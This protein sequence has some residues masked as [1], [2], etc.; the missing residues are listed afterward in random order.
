MSEAYTFNSGTGSVT[1]TTPANCLWSASSNVGWLEITSEDGGPGDGSVDYSVS[2]NTGPGQR[3]GS[4]NIAGYVFNVAQE[5]DQDSFDTEAHYL[6]YKVIPSRLVPNGTLPRKWNL[7]L[8]DANL[9]NVDG[10]DPE[11]YEVKKVLSLLNPARKNN[12]SNPGES[13]LHYLRYLIRR[14]WRPTA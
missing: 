8:D 13:G 1:V 5:G 14:Y 2:E 9:D 11:N 12:E 3:V 4:L 6:E 7:T 10:D